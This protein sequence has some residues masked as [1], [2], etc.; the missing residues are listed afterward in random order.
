MQHYFLLFIFSVFSFQTFASECSAVNLITDPDSPFQK[1]PVYDQK[2]TNICYAY[3]ASQMANYY[4]MKK[5][6]TEKVHPAWVALNYA[7]DKGKKSLYIGHTKESLEALQR[8]SSCLYNR[9]SDALKNWSMT[10]EKSEARVLHKMEK[11]RTPAVETLSSVLAVPCGQSERINVRLPAVVRKNF[12][13]LPDDESFEKFMLNQL[14]KRAEP[15]SIAYC[16]RVWKEPD[17]DGIDVTTSGIRDSL[18][19]DCDYHESLVV[20]KKLVNNSC[21][22]L[23]RNTWGNHWRKENRQ[24]RCLCKEKLTGQ[25]VDDCDPE[26]H[27]DDQFSVEACWIPSEKLG[28]NTG[29]ITLFEEN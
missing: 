5:G 13:Q 3:S 11:G 9:V 16:S 12:Q 21:H 2:Q 18:K 29:V 6:E 24:W 26:T 4:L 28:R 10:D 15:F 23:V 25:F 20:G 1:L 8:V 22:L 17:Y 27:S 19:K 14:D 7:K